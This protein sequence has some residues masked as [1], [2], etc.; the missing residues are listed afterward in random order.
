MLRFTTFRYAI[1]LATRRNKCAIV[2]V[3][4]EHRTANFRHTDGA[5]G[6][7][8]FFLMF[9]RTSAYLRRHDD[10]DSARLFAE[11]I[12]MTTPAREFSHNDR[13]FGRRS[14][15]PCH[16]LKCPIILDYPRYI[17]RAHAA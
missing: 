2:F 13:T 10:I 11:F 5:F 17:F 15:L 12:R 1:L 3:H 7:R 9:P 6:R 8:S 16:A 4:D 14:G